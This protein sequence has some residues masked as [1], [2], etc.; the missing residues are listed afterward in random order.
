[1]QSHAL[2]VHKRDVYLPIYISLNS[3]TLLSFAHVYVV[4]G[5]S[6]D[7]RRLCVKKQGGGVETFLCA[8]EQ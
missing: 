7:W 8:E 4:R 1:M 6:V 5:A 3:N 2:C